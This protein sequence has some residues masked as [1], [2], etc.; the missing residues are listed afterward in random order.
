MLK[1]LFIFGALA[2]FIWGVW[3]VPRFWR[4][5][6][7][8]RLEQNPFAPRWV[9]RALRRQAHICIA[10]I[11]A[12]LVFIGTRPVHSD[13]SLVNGVSAIL[14]LALLGIIASIALVNRPRSLVPKRFRREPGAVQELVSY[15]MSRGRR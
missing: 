7:E 8:Y 12:F 9:Q 6:R 14:F 3:G 4:G 2:L 13:H 5:S 11:I 1:L 10:V 15:V